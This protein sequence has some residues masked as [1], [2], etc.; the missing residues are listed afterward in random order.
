MCVL[1]S[2][3]PALCVSG[4]SLC[5]VESCLGSVSLTGQGFIFT[6]IGFPFHRNGFFST[7][8]SPGFFFHRNLVL[9]SPKLFW[10]CT[11]F[12]IDNFCLF[13]ETYVEFDFFPCL[14]NRLG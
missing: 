11:E 4:S 9:I 2:C 12:E 1:E 7:E 10:T 3:L 6:E 8:I 13:K 14:K 5:L